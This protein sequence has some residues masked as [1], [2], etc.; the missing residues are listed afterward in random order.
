M[1]LEIEVLLFAG[2]LFFRLK[3]YQ[4][5]TVVVFIRILHTFLATDLPYSSCGL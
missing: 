2:I 3:I 5:P 1:D 4:I